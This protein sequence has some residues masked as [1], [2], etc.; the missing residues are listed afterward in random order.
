MPAI[1]QPA[2]E[3]AIPK[4]IVTNDVFEILIRHDDT[5]LEVQINPDPTPFELLIAK[6][7]KIEAKY[8]LPTQ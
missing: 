8:I 2:C 5:M 1:N 4:T 7:S 6:R 3:I